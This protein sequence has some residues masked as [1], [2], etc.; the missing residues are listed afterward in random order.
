MTTKKPDGASAL[1]D[2]LRPE[3]DKPEPSKIEALIAK[4][5][6]RPRRTFPVTVL[7]DDMPFTIEFTEIWG[8]EWND[9]AAVCPPR[10]GAPGDLEYRFN[11][12]ALVAVYPA[13][14]IRI[15]GDEPTQEVWAELVGYMDA[16][17]REDI[18][19]ALWAVHVL[20]P[21]HRR[22]TALSEQEEGDAHG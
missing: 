2:A 5:K 17:A 13:A 10:A 19:A 7:A 4:A 14:S 20:E 22:V 3:I 9:L 1:L 21:R 8:R 12:H 18:A 15:N 6:A 11:P 16:A